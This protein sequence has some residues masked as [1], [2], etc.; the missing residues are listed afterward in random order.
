MNPLYFSLNFNFCGFYIF[1]EAHQIMETDGSITKSKIIAYLNK[2]LDNSE[3]L[4]VDKWLALSSKNMNFFNEVRKEWLAR[5]EEKDIEK[6]ENLARNQ[7][8]PARTESGEKLVPVKDAAGKSRAVV[9]VIAIALA[10][11]GM[12]IAMFLGASSNN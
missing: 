7:A 4:R 3:M 11:M 5:K 10:I 2:D 8:K 12:A 1:K 6:K 9:L